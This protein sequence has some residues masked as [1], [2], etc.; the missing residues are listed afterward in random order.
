MRRHTADPLRATALISCSN[1]RCTSLN[2]LRKTEKPTTCGVTPG[3]R[4]STS[5]DQ[6]GKEGNLMSCR[7]RW[8]GL[9]GEITHSLKKKQLIFFPPQSRNKVAQ[10][11]TNTNRGVKGTDGVGFFRH[12]SPSPNTANVCVL[13]DMS[14]EP[15]L[16]SL[17]PILSS[18]GPVLSSPGAGPLQPR[19]LRDPQRLQE[20]L[21]L[22]W[23]APLVLGDFPP[24]LFGRV[25]VVVLLVSGHGLHRRE[26]TSA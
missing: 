25:L 6:G 12:P 13:T 18:P 8:M 16:S 7:N 14:Q 3:W 22:F 23:V 26:G 10:K 15:V 17:E 11:T 2:V 24:D 1:D 5:R 19:W 20:G 21:E 4:E 9:G